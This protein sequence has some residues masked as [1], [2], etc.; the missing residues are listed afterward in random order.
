MPT[1]LK[2]LAGK[3]TQVRF[4]DHG[5][6]LKRPIGRLGRH[7]RS[8]ELSQLVLNERHQFGGGATIAALRRVQ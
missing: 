4:V 6:G 1:A 5:G 3:Q 8:R 7:S 2:L